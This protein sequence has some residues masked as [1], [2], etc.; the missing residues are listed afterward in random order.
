M[1]IVTAAQMREIDEECARQGTPT[2]K[3]MENAGRAV[4]EATRDYIGNVK[5]LNILCLTGAGNN[6]GDGLVA[7]RHLD[8]WGAKCTVYLGSERP[9][10]DPN[11]KLINSRGIPVYEAKA[12]TYGKKLESLLEESNIV[13]DA[14]LGTGKMRPLEG[15]FKQVLE[16]TNAAK[17]ARNIKIIAVDLPSGMN[18]DTGAID[19]A[20][21]AADLT[22]TLAF[23]KPGLYKFPGAEM[24][25]KVVI[26]DIGIPKS[27][28]DDI[29][30]ELLTA[31]WA[32]ELLPKRPLNANK[33][34]F[35]RALVIAGSAN[36][37][38]AAY[39]ATAGALRVGAG[40]VTLAATG[41][42]QA[43]VA[44][45]LAE[46]IYR[47]M[48]ET[49]QGGIAA[50]AADIIVKELDTYKVVLT[51]CGL[52][53]ETATAEFLAAL[54]F[55]PGLPPLVLDADA[56]NILAGIPEWYKKLPQSVIMTPHPGEMSR[57]TGLTI[58]KVQADR[59][60]TAKKYAAAWKKVVVLKGAFTV[61][62][63]P[64]GRCRISPFANPSLATAGTGDVLAGAITG[65]AAQGLELY[66]AAALGV[67]LHAAAGEKV[68]AEMGDTGTIA[69][70]LLPALPLV[71]KQLK[72]QG[73]IKGNK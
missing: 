58:E 20:C 1:K 59:T 3:L 26:A 5:K 37:T 14:L 18:A 16:K 30:S 54:L 70:D 73:Y 13:I 7:A 22:V 55:K 69:S 36:Y 9:A 67:Y 51:G 57:L 60:A 48:L 45:R 24:T 61:I 34:T 44:A 10:D 8:D 15:V 56:L 53:Q 46:V 4:A 11:L 32:A 40:L 33:G 23:P 38:G 62:A 42:V 12:D 64:D 41:T 68:K 71:I 21:P 63:A 50:G 35:G 27:L 43:S 25:G 29:K 66:D 19:P 17:K 31:D 2:G 39:L 47:P 28:A 65:L 6:G 52:T 49:K 72:D